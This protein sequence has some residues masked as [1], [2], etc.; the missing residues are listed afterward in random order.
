MKPSSALWATLPFVYAL[1]VLLTYLLSRVMR[2]VK[3]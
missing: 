2:K 3:R 1:M